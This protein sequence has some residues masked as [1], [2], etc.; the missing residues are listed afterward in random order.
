MIDRHELDRRTVLRAVGAT[1][2]LAVGASALAACGGSANAGSSGAGSSAG[3]AVTVAT[4]KVPVGSGVILTD[5]GGVVVVQPTAGDFKAFSA[6]CPH[7][8][9]QVDS[10]DS[11][12]ITCPCHGSEFNVTDGAVIQGP[13]Q[14]G[15]TALTATVSGAN[16]VVT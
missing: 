6:V 16:V 9:C 3:G 4:S 2:A 1:G 11:S 14:S 13:A 10:I 5:G 7:Q 8:G 15:L 12:K